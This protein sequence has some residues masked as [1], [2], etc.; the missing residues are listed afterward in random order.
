MNEVMIV[1]ILKSC[2]FFSYLYF[3]VFM[4]WSSNRA[5]ISEFN[6]FYENKVNLVG[7]LGGQ[8][9]KISIF[10]NSAR[11]NRKKVAEKLK[12]LCKTSL[13]QN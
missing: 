1:L 3:F 2:V 11:K 10:F 7:I 12:F 8:G 6:K 13:R 5:L 4:F 9:K